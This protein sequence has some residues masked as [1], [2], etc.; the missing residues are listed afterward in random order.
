ML[1]DL[2]DEEFQKRRQ[3]LRDQLAQILSRDAQ[4][5]E[6]LTRVPNS[7]GSYLE[8]MTEAE[9]KRIMRL[10]FRTVSIRDEIS[11]LE[12]RKPFRSLFERQKELQSLLPSVSP[13]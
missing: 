2:A 4:T 10:L 8:Q 6:M 11:N 7:L 5:E 9:R 13:Q 3:G 1:G 12:P